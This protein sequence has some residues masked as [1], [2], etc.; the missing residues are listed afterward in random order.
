MEL[1]INGKTYTI[2]DEQKSRT[3][4]WVLRDELGLTGTKF[5]CGAGICGSCTVL[6]DGKLVRSCMQTTAGVEGKHVTTIEGLAVVKEGE[7]KL[8][9]VQ[10][11]FLE[12]QTP[13]CGYCMPGQMITAADLLAENPSPSED[14]IIAGMSGVYCRCGT[15]VRIKAAVA[16]AAEIMAEE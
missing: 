14:E 7:E 11:A 4:L 10:Q 13:Q 9:P 8:H 15:Y 5:G 1:L 2:S 6:V 16:R 3:L 12:T